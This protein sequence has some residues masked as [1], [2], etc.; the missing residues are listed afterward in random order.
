M[1]PLTEADLARQDPGA[2]RSYALEVLHWTA[3]VAPAMSF[4]FPL[5]LRRALLRLAGWIVEPTGC[6][7]IIELSEVS[8]VT[9][10]RSPVYHRKDSDHLEHI[11]TIFNII[12]TCP[13]KD[14]IMVT[15]PKRETR[16]PSK[17]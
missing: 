14:T 8:P 9:G 6:A 2:L 10:S 1:R 3:R 5:W 16:P 17:A 11:R 4:P 15:C 13:K 12:V 7:V